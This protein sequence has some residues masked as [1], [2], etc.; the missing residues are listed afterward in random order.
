MA[1]RA[2]NGKL[3]VDVELVAQLLFGR[4]SMSYIVMA[5]VSVV[6]VRLTIAL[7]YPKRVDWD[8]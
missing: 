8:E 5:A 6:I 4:R 1:A 2:I 7:I 3:A